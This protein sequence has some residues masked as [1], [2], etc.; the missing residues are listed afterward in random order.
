[1][2]Y[3][4]S[5]SN[6]VDWS[7][8]WSRQG[9]DDI[10]E[11]DPP[12]PRTTNEIHASPAIADLD[13][14][15]HLDIVIAMGGD[16]HVSKDKRENGGVLV[17]RYN[18]AWDFSLIEEL[19]ADGSRGWPQPRIDQV[20]AGPGYGDPDDLWDG[21]ITTPALGDLDGDGDLEIV[22]AGI[23]RR[24]H[25]WHHTGEVVEGWPIYRYAE[26]GSDTGDNL[27]RGSH[28]S[29]PAL[30]DIDGDG[31]P[32][33]VVGTMSPPW[34][35]KTDPDYNKGT[36]WAINGDS[37]N[38]P[39]FPLE[40]EQ[41]IHS[42]PAL[43]D[44]DNDGQL[45]IVVGVGWGTSGRQNIVYAW[46]HDGTSLPNWPQETAGVM[47]APPALGDID[48][49]GELEIVIGCGNHIKRD[50]CGDGDAKLYAWNADGTSVPNFPVE[51]PTP[52][53]WLPEGNSYAMPFNP[54]LADFDGDGDVEIL[55]A[56][57]AA[58]GITIVDPDGTTF[59][60]TSYPFP[61]GG[62][63][64]PPVVDDIDSD[65]DLEML[66]G[67]GR[68]NGVIRIW[69]ESGP[70]NSELP[71]PMFRRNVL[72]NGRYP[73]PPQLGFASELRFY[74]Q[75]GSGATETLHTAIKNLGEV[76]FDWQITN[77]ITTLQVN[78]TSGTVLTQTNV[79]F[80]V[81]TTSYLTSTWHNLG[82]LDVSGTVDGEHIFYSPMS[83]PVWLYVGDIS[84]VYLPLT[85]R[86]Y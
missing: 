52:T 45:E 78:P 40:T 65:G 39:G 37:T 80:V 28:L 16:I 56:H 69:D 60:H 49:D 63:Y 85:L 83:V 42:S 38:V 30:G 72:R 76:E 31:L 24:F 1:M 41:Y 7:V 73:V 62:L 64:A 43:G 77:P 55:V 25:A 23:D 17:Y 13:G 5:T 35:R 58:E 53:S 82:N 57:I 21:I 18:S 27:L 32:E 47:S 3:V 29:S 50:S 14:D 6:G 22:V 36:V 84:R 54:I 19:S 4:V 46:N 79:Q 44:I 20:G 71:W 10:L 8:V 51:P 12:T 15:G 66:A 59:D 81:T 33:V 2:L 68:Y 9:N 34:D 61:G 75:E 67:G 86:H 74:H 70:N 11:A 26:D 48:N